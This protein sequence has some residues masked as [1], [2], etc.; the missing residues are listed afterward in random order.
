VWTVTHPARYHLHWAGQRNSAPDNFSATK[1][2]LTMR[3]KALLAV[4][5]AAISLFWCS[6]TSPDNGFSNKLLLGTG[7]NATNPFNLTGQ[8]TSFTGAPLALYWRLESKDDMAGSQV[9]I[10]IKKLTGGTYVAHMSQTFANPQSY[11]HIMVSAVT[12]D[13]VGS[14]RA[15]GILVT[16]NK[17]ISSVD[18]TV[19]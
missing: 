16:G 17:I 4:T 7:Q 1:G 11:G 14:F 13:S 6:P 3:Q 9:T 12:I 2:G 15:T 10:D 18:F 8:G 19:Q 5:L